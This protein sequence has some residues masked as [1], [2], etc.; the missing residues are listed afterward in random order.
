[1]TDAPLPI[2]RARNT[3]PPPV[4]FASR[5]MSEIVEQAQMLAKAGDALPKAY[6][7]N[8]G[9]CLLAVDLAGRINRPLLWVLQ[10]VAFVNGRQVLEA[11]GVIDIAT[12]HDYAV[13]LLELDDHHATVGLIDTRTGEQVAEWTSTMADRNKR[14]DIWDT[15]PR[16]MLRANAIRNVW[17]FYGQPRGGGPFLVS[18]DDFLDA[19]ELPTP[20]PL[21]V[22]APPAPEP[23]AGP[24]A[25]QA[26]GPVSEAEL[27]AS[28]KAA[29]STLAEVMREFQAKSVADLLHPDTLPKVAAWLEGDR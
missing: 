9:A 22:L 18:A 28:I 6:R 25:E 8:P 20:D 17:K 1:M 2:L 13:K 21:H 7:G 19:D 29:G 23:D 14:N 5:P 11:N 24:V 16:H 4:A 27:R 15:H 3:A 12:D 10:N 26:A